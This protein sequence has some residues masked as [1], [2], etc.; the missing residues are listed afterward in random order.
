MAEQGRLPVDRL[1]GDRGHRRRRHTCAGA[2]TP[3]HTLG[4]GSGLSVAYVVAS[5]THG[6][7]QIYGLVVVRHRENRDK[8][9]AQAS[10]L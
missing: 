1:E 5:P 10:A 8:F 4:A 6:P 3:S 2:P 7:A 9:R